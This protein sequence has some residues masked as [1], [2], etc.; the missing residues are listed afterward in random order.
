[1]FSGVIF[2]FTLLQAYCLLG[3]FMAR[4]WHEGVYPAALTPLCK[5]DK[6]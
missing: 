3:G 2:D 1:M 5:A 6:A 4:E